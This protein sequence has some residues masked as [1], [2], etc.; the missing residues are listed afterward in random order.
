MPKAPSQRTRG[1]NSPILLVSV[2]EKKHHQSKQ[3]PERNDEVKTFLL[4]IPYRPLW[5]YRPPPLQLS[6][7]WY[8]FLLLVKEWWIFGTRPLLFLSQN[9]LKLLR[10]KKILH[11]LSTP[12]NS[13]QYFFGCF[14]SHRNQEPRSLCIKSFSMDEL[15]PLFHSPSS[16]LKWRLSPFLE[17]WCGCGSAWL[18]SKLYKCANKTQTLLLLHVLCIWCPT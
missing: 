17:S 8:W 13:F 3:P 6:L 7:L 10:N 15:L 16:R 11:S 14:V 9:K 4:K 5:V 2:S 12:R 18:L 1:I